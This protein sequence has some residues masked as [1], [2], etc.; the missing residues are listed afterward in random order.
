MTLPDAAQ[1]ARGFVVCG[2]CGPYRAPLRLATASTVAEAAEIVN[3][4]KRDLGHVAKII[5]PAATPGVPLTRLD[6]PRFAFLCV[7]ERRCY[8]PFVV[9][10]IA[11]SMA[12]RHVVERPGHQVTILVPETGARP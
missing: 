8:G 4:H 9:L 3:V 6:E 7:Q 2:A 1:S 12:A 11:R 10:P 5:W